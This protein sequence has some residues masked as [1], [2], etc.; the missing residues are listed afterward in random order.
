MA[1][2]TQKE[3]RTSTR[4]GGNGA[5]SHEV[6]A[7][8]DQVKRD[9]ASLTDTLS[10]FGKAQISKTK[11]KASAHTDAAVADAELKLQELRM[12]AENIGRQIE[13]RVR[14]KPLQT[15]AMAAG[16]GFIL[17]MLLRR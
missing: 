14:A 17:S 5:T 9:I 2:T 8:L 13:G 11:G 3:T 6:E 16:A 7:S 4:I 15:L 10:S 1:T 12:Q